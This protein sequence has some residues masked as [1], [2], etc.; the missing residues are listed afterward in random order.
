MNNFHSN[1]SKLCSRLKINNASIGSC[2]VLK[3]PKRVVAISCAHVIYGEEHETTIVDAN[4][5]TVEIDGTAHICSKILSPL[6]DSKATDMVVIELADTTLLST[7]SLCELKVCL[8]V[9]ESILGY[10]QAMVLLPIQDSCHSVVS[11]TKFNKEVDEHSFQVEVHKQTFVDYDKGAAGAAAFKGISGSGLFVDMNDSIYLAGILSKLPKSSVAS[12]VVF[13]SLKPLTSILPELKESISLKKGTSSTPGDINDVCF[14]NYTGR[15][16]K[17]YQER[18]CD[19]DF[20]SNIKHNRNIWLSG[21]SGTGKTAIL[22]RNLIDNKVNYIYCDLQPVEISSPLDIWQGVIEDVESHTE[23]KFENK[24]FTVKFM[25]KYLLSCNFKSDTILVIDEMS[26]SKKDIIED[27]CKD[28]IALVSYYIK[29][30]KTKNLTFVISSIFSPSKTEFNYGKF[31]ESFDNLSSNEWTD[32]ISN[33]F[34]I[35]NSSL[36]NRITPE[37]KELILSHC[38]SLPRL[39]T[40]I[41]SRIYRAND[42]EIS[43]IHQACKKLTKEYYEYV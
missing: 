35:Q 7:S 1:S 39:L 19:R 42:F 18:A 21:D 11:L 27:F 17:Y 30:S 36:G 12:T 43:S 31:L 25:T 24:E 4:Q 13:Q 16:Q 34:D 14:V 23:K 8:D 29:Q 10:K 22:L 15:S 6:A 37:G 38:G 5:I 32:S 2:V 28:A 3:T 20:C 40:L 33:L 9:N 41:I 26:C